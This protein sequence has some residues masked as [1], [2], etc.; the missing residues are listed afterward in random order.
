MLERQEVAELLPRRWRHPEARKPRPLR[1]QV[2]PRFCVAHVSPT[3]PMRPPSISKEIDQKD[4]PAASMPVVIRAVRLLPFTGRKKGGREEGQVDPFPG[5]GQQ[6]MPGE[7]RRSCLPLSSPSGWPADFPCGPVRI[8]SSLSS[9]GARP[10]S[11]RVKYRARPALPAV[12]PRAQSSARELA[13][14]VA[15]HAGQALQG[16]GLAVKGSPGRRAEATS[17]SAAGSFRR[18]A[19][20]SERRRRECRRKRPTTPKCCPGTRKIGLARKTC[21]AT[22]TRY[23]PSRASGR[24]RSLPFRRRSG[25][26]ASRL[27][28]ASSTRGWAAPQEAGAD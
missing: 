11:P 13:G 10:F 8:S 4:F 19:S 7:R 6:G 16:E 28:G 26:L 20:A 27:P 1:L 24:G 9:T 12:V 17:R 15:A 2:I 22:R 18:A 3:G 23:A 25:K 14:R 21:P 5:A